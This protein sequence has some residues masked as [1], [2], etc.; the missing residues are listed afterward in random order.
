M[1]PPVSVLA[2]DLLATPESVPA[3]RRL[4]R[5]YG[6][7]LQLCADELLTNV[8]RHV[9]AGA[10]VTLRVTC[11]RGRM[12]LAVTD[13]DPRA[14]PVLRSAAEDDEGGRGLALLDALSL[15]WG[16]EQAPGGKTIWCELPGPTGHG[17]GGQGAGTSGEAVGPAGASM[18]GRYASGT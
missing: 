4:L 17:H 12:R 9:G 2:L 10:P 11:D 3:T 15:R 16:V 13:P 18:S 7:D 8:I 14:L 5:A 6:G 1:R